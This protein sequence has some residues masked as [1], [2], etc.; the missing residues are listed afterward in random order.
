MIEFLKIELKLEQELKL[1]IFKNQMEAAKMEKEDCID[2]ILSL[3]RQGFIKDNVI[4]QLMKENI[5]DE[6]KKC[7]EQ[8]EP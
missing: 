2:L 6:F 3:V 1:T 4:Q 7:Q 5:Q 8:L